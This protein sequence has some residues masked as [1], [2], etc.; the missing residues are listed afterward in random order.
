MVYV[1]DDSVKK[2]LCLAALGAMLIGTT[3][4]AQATK[5]R[6]SSYTDEAH[7]FTLEAPRFPGAGPNVAAIP[8]VVSGPAEGGF[9]S[10]VNVGIQASKTTRKG[11]RELSLG[12]FR[13]IGLKVNSDRDVT[14]SGR[15]AIRFDYEGQL[16][17]RDLHFLTLAVIDKERVVLVTCTASAAAFPA[18]APEFNACLDSFKLR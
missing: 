11:Y 6:R 3:W 7:G 10:S 5:A 12:Q 8:L 14:V 2:P 4:A 18:V 17:G 15:E 1:G 13:Q 16:Q 9:A